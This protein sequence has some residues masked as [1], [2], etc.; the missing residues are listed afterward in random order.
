MAMNREQCRNV[1]KLAELILEPIRA[2]FGRYHTESW[3][4]SKELNGRIGGSDNPDHLYGRAH[5]GWPLGDKTAWDVF[6]GVYKNLK[7]D[8][9]SVY[10][11]QGSDLL[12][13]GVR[14]SLKVAPDVKELEKE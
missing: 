7:G 2:E 5:D 6:R 12:G 10:L 4:S 13:G 9:R 8:F 3:F 11:L 14:S 1:K